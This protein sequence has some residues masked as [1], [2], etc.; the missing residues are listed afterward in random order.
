[1]LK[2]QYSSDGATYLVKCNARI[3]VMMT[4]PTTTAIGGTMYEGGWVISNAYTVT[5]PSDKLPD[6]MKLFAIVLASYHIDPHFFNTVAQARD[7]IQRN[8]YQ[9]LGE[10]ME[11]SR[12]ISRTNDEI[13]ASIDSQ[14]KTSQAALDRESENFDD[15]IRGV[16]RYQESDGE[17][18]LPSGYSHAWSDGNGKYL[19]TDEHLYDPNV[20]G[21]GGTWH[22]MEK[23]R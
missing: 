12:I 22:E 10:I 20:N 1:V 13:S 23:T 9:R 15:Y 19:V 21:P 18:G 4:I 17:V 14:Y 2:L 3:D 11:T 6:A 5:A 16:D 7:I 8:F